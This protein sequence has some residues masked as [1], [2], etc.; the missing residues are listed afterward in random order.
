MILFLLLSVAQAA[1]CLATS[2]PEAIAAKFDAAEEAYK[3]LE[4]DIFSASLDEAALMLPCLDAAVTPAFAARYH[5]MRGLRSYIERDAAKAAQSFAAARVIEPDYSFPTSLIPEGHSVRKQFSSVDTTAPQTQPAPE[6]V[7]GWLSLDGTRTLDRSMGWP[8]IVQL[9]SGEG[10]LSSTSYLF[11]S[12]PLPAY[13]AKAQPVSSSTVHKPLSP[14]IPLAIGAGVA[15]IGAGVL[16]AMADA[17]AQDFARYD[18]SYSTDDLT[19]MQ[20]K[21][22]TFVYASIGSGALAV[23]GTLGVVLVGHW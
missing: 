12:D 9:H 22:N 19:A 4:V 17:S 10:A 2:T 14:K 6:P 21:T 3:S 15:A 1:D 8:A 20:T 16:Y 11:P 13:K 7:E 5:R 18:E 23:A